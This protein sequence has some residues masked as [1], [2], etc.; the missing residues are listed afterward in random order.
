MKCARSA[1]AVQGAATQRLFELTNKNK[2]L[3][4]EKHGGAARPEPGRAACI[5]SKTMK[6]VRCSMAVW[7]EATGMKKRGLHQ[8]QKDEVRAM[9]DGGVERSDCSF[10]PAKIFAS[11]TVSAAKHEPAARPWPGRAAC[12]RSRRLKGERRSMAVWSGA[13]KMKGTLA[14]PLFCGLKSDYFFFLPPFFLPPFFFVA[15]FLFSLFPFIH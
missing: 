14:R 6:C 3:S 9:L 2:N 13:T 1:M 8:E 4:D 10:S 12:I 5:R 15:M 11:K 7:S